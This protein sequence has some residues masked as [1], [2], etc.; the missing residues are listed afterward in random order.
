[1]NSM[2]QAK[3]GTTDEGKIF[4]YSVGAVLER[5]GKYL[6]IDRSKI[7]YGFAGPAGHIDEDEEPEVAIKR[8]VYE[9]TGL[10]VTGHD[11][12]FAEM[13]DWNECSYE[14]KGH[15]WYLYKCEFFGDVLEDST[16]AKSIG[17]Y[18]IDE[19]RSIKLEPVWKYWFEKLGIIL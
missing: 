13:I 18:T 1:M 12:L 5:D 6:M 10:N 17:W 15:Y 19:I 4:H 14:V 9:E 7:P 11:L 2:S 3:Q 8:E 16:E